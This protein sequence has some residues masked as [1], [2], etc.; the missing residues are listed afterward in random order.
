MSEKGDTISTIRE[1]YKDLTAF[2]QKYKHS[3]INIILFG[4]IKKIK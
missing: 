1:T 2:G 3:R 4:D